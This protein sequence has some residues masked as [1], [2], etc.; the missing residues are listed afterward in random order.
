MKSFWTCLSVSVM[1][2]LVS[3]TQPV[4]VLQHFLSGL[5]PSLPFSSMD[6]SCTQQLHFMKNLMVSHACSKVVTLQPTEL[7]PFFFTSL[8]MIS[9]RSTCD[10]PLLS[11]YSLS[12]SLW[13]RHPTSGGPALICLK[14]CSL[15]HAF[16]LPAKPFLI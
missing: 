2:A 15:A 8:S 7:R 4:A 14:L 11:Y 13:L 10:L 1:P 5:D 12:S 3:I 6:P 16:T 9:Q